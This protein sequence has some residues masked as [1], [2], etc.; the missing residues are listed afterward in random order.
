M[1]FLKKVGAIALAFTIAMSFSG[2]GDKVTISGE[3]MDEK[4]ETTQTK[5]YVIATNISSPPFEFKNFLDDYVGIDVDLL[6]AIA[7]KQGF[8]YEFVPMSF[9]NILQALDNGE[10]DGAMAGIFITE[11]RKERYDYSQP[12]LGSGIVLA[13]NASR[14]DINSYE[15]LA[16]KQVA[17]TRG[18]IAE[19]FAESI[20]DKY[21][22][23]IISFDEY[24]DTYKNVLKGNSQAIFED[25][26]VVG[27]L[28]SYGF[29]LNVVSDIG[30]SYFYGFAVPKGK[31]PELIEMF[32]NGLNEIIESGEYEKILDAY[33]QN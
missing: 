32:N 11:E 33:I 2:C 13:V 22:F 24:T 8:T 7:E 16:G 29:D 17:V 20:K 30:Q 26:L 28:I 9:N 1:F 4:E 15:D 21:G 31:N 5:K 12:Y 14:R 3:N 27:F 10:V 19:E 23:S 25:N 18:T 6:N